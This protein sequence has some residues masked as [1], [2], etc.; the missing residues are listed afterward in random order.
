V[1]WA[2]TAALGFALVLVGAVG[3][4][5]AAQLKPRW[6]HV[7]NTSGVLVGTRYVFVDKPPALDG[8]VPPGGTL[9]DEQ[10]G[11]TT[12][13]VPPVPSGYS[14]AGGGVTIG[15]PWLAFVCWVPS[16]TSQPVDYEIE[17]YRLA[18]GGWRLVQ[19]L[20]S[21]PV[22]RV[23][24][25]WI[26]YWVPN[27][28]AIAQQLVFQN[29]YTGQTRTLPG[30]RPG[31]RTVPNLSSPSLAQ[32][33]CAPLHVPD[34]WE[35]T[36]E[37]WP[38]T[39]SLFGNYAIV[40]GTSENNRAFGYLERCGTRA[41]RPIGPVGPLGNGYAAANA[42]AVLWQPSPMS[43]LAGAY[44]PTLKRFTVDTT[45]LVNSIDSPYTGPN[46]YLSWLTSRLLYVLVQPYYPGDCTPTP[47]PAP[48]AQLYAAPSPSQPNERTRLP[49]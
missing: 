26:E 44:L 48:P 28:T 18:T 43:D 9:I 13:V 37:E 24:A 1:R 5:S 39:V 34:A 19:R 27:P 17:L 10:T 42:H 30:W 23:G 32:R 41:R 49:R 15:G 6:R 8:S 2:T 22:Q 45:D 47:C 20:V 14:C 38:A 21:G 31:G 7:A 36:S 35:S 16:Q 11:K 46:S 4:A 3:V 29:I 12:T 25:D 40:G 33:L